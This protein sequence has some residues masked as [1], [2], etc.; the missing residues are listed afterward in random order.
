M[1]STTTQTPGD[2][3]DGDELGEGLGDGWG[4]LGE[5]PGVVVQDG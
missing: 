3:D 1:P 2:P 4:G 5:E